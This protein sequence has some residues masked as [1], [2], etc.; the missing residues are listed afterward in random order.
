MAATQYKTIHFTD[1]NS[2]F[3]W[4]VKAYLSN[5]NRFTK[6]YPLVFFGEFLSKAI[7]EKIKIKDDDTYKIL[8]VRSYGKG[9]FENRIV[10]GNTLKMKE[11]FR[12]KANHLFWCKVD[13]K[14]GAF[15]I[16]KNDLAD[17]LGSTNMTF[18]EIDTN[19]INVDFLQLLFTSKGVMQYLDSYVTGTTNRKYIRPDQLLNEIKIPLPTLTEQQKIVISYQA[20]IQQAQALQVKASNLEQEVEKYLFDE[21]AF[22]IGSERK[23]IKGLQFINYKD[24]EFWGTDKLLQHAQTENSKHSLLSLNAKPEIVDEIYRGKSPKYDSSSNK[25]ILNQ[26]C[27]RWNAI[28]LEHSKK[29]DEVWVSKIDEILFTKVGDILINSTG[30]GTIGRASFVT[31]KFEG[32]M[33]DS[34]ILLLRLNKVIINPEFYVEFFNSKIIQKQIENLKSAQSTNQTELGIANL[35]KIV[36]PLPPINKQ[37]EILNEIKKMQSQILQFRIDYTQ[38]IINAQ[39][40]FEIQIFV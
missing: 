12:A 3:S 38:L 17:G 6:E 40:E 39:Q 24:I 29:V 21:L 18:A 32:L 4:D 36:F 30:E 10:K 28:E 31:K 20:K 33:Y 37:D 8:G 35:K 23:K 34:H 27:N 15:G 19:K 14:N 25:L 2:L 11:Y 16:I 13:T 9:V 1:F 5:S 26:K 22:E 7:V